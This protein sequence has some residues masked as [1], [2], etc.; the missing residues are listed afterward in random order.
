M[1]GPG[2]AH[3]MS[4]LSAS[5]LLPFHAP[6]FPRLII[7]ESVLLCIRNLMVKCLRNSANHQC[8]ESGGCVCVCLLMGAMSLDL[9]PLG[10]WVASLSNPTEIFLEL[11]FLSFSFVHI[12]I[13]FELLLWQVVKAC[14]LYLIA[15]PEH[16]SKM[17][18]FWR[19]LTSSF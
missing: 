4:L 1:W 11:D 6:D 15:W 7:L 5:S 13:I 2:L 9:S 8:P 10:L 19:N 18:K 14:Q 17:T 12:T 3:C 16:L